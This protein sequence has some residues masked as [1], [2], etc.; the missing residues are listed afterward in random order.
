MMIILITLGWILAA[1]AAAAALA[2]IILT[3]IIVIFQSRLVYSPTRKMNTSPADIGLDFEEI[4]LRTSDNINLTAWMI[5]AAS[6]NGVLLFCHGNSGN[7]SNRL[8]SI[9]IFNQ[10]GLSVFVFDYRGYG[11]SDGQPSENGT[12]NDAL[13]AWQYLISRRN[14]SPNDI[15]IF[16]R[17]LGGAVAAWL[18]SRYSPRFLIVEGGFTSIADVGS[19]LYPYLLVR[20]FIR[21]D[22]RTIDYIKKV[23]CPILIIHSVDDKVSSIHYGRKLYEAA[24]NPKEFLEIRGNHYDGFLTSGESYIAGLKSF[25]MKH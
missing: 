13:A 24:G 10:L 17:S 23:K 3:A 5:P 11:R 6:P 2:Y 22:Y 25:L 9:R 14:V 4:T 12:Y 8:D 7:I 20:P 18:A 21:Y 19:D 15:I 1:I 16:G